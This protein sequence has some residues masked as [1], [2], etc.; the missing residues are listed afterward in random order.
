MNT[1]TPI[2]SPFSGSQTIAELLSQPNSVTADLVQAVTALQQMVT[3]LVTENAALHQQ[4][5]DLTT[6]VAKFLSAP[7]LQPTAHVRPEPNE[8]PL[9][10]QA[11]PP[12]GAKGAMESN[13][14]TVTSKHKPIR[15]LTSPRRI[16]ANARG[17]TPV[18]GPQGFDHLY[19]H[20]SC[21]MD[22]A[23]VCRRLRRFGID[24]SRILDVSFP[25]RNIIGLLLHVQYI[26]I[27]RDLLEKA[28]VSPIANFD[29]T[30]PTNLG[31]PKY[32]SHSLEHRTALALQLHRERCIQTLKYLRPHIAVPIAH[33]F[34][35]C[36][37]ILA[38][39]HATFTT[40]GPYVD[41]DKFPSDTESSSLQPETEM[42]LDGAFSSRPTS[43]AS[44]YSNN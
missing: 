38:S 30:D 15:P 42:D 22:R 10:T 33:A 4:I 9:P 6:Q 29:P 34:Y 3:T 40:S 24:S 44:H 18:T 16:A 21:R 5:L 25:A 43:R 12:T 26:P 23:E 2:V 31:D 35:Q 19:L 20:R 37:W 1:A 27:V 8:S 7:A 36:G 14:A 28:T 39:D 17:F 13:W 41:R 11:T 32:A